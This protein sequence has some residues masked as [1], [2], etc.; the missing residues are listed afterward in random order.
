MVLAIKTLFKHGVSR[1]L[2]EFHGVYY[3]KLNIIN[4]SATPFSLRETPWLSEQIPLK[5]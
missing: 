5:P 1:C 4:N 3:K 2:W